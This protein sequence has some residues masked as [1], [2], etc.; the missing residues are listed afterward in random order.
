M[1]YTNSAIYSISLR[2]CTQNCKRGKYLLQ[3]TIL[4][5]LYDIFFLYLHHFCLFP[6]C[7]CVN[8][9]NR[10]WTRDHNFESTPKII[11]KI[12][13]TELNKHKRSG[14]IAGPHSNRIWIENPIHEYFEFICLIS[15]L[16]ILS[17]ACKLECQSERR[18]DMECKRHRIV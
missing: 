4:L 3:R 2:L 7:R 9:V 18:V 8:Q 6:F 12:S 1:S 10:Q 5:L 14:K 13:P 15:V 11:S 17:D 16:L